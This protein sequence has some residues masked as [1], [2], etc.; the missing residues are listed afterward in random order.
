VDPVQAADGGFGGRTVAEDEIHRRSQGAPQPTERI[1]TEIAVCGDTLGDERVR[2]LQ[3]QRGRTRAQEDRERFWQEARSVGTRM[4]I[5]LDVSPPDWSSLQEWFE[6]MLAP[7]GPITVTPTALALAPDIVRPPLPLVPGPFVDL[8]TLPG[9]ALLPERLR[10]EYRIAWSTRRD[11][12]ARSLDLGVRAWVAVAPRGWRAM[13]Q[14]RAADHRA[15]TQ[16]GGTL[17]DHTGPHLEW[18]DRPSPHHD[19]R[20]T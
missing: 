2:D 14:A 1:G 10:D 19:L 11:R 12:L 20:R 9:L 3:E 4:G 15:R 17:R 5:P 8:L 16:R 18:A 6:R 13:P 7:G